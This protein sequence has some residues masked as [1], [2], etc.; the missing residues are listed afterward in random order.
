MAEAKQTMA[1][2]NLIEKYTNELNEKMSHSEN[3]RLELEMHKIE[4]AVKESLGEMSEADCEASEALID[5]LSIQISTL[6]TDVSKCDKMIKAI[7]EV[8]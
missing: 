6:D 5:Y 2:K 3:L 1:H 8:K 7:K 4:R